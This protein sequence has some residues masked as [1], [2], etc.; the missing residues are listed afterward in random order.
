MGVIL[1]L[2]HAGEHLPGSARKLLHDTH[3]GLPVQLVV[4]DFIGR[5][6][7]LLQK[8]PLDVEFGKIFADHIVVLVAQDRVVFRQQHNA[9]ALPKIHSLQKVGNLCQLQIQY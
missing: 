2:G 5:L 6:L 7:Q 3:A 1:R 8:F 9:S 4:Y